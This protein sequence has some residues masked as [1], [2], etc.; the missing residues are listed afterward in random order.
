VKP[1]A[2]AAAAAAPAATAPAPA[3]TAKAE[4]VAAPAQAAAAAPAPAK[5]EPVAAA[6]APQKA[7]PVASSDG[8]DA[9]SGSSSQ[10]IDAA[11]RMLNAGDAAGA[12]L[13]MR[14]LLVAD[15]GEHHA[16]EMLARALLAQSKAQEALPLIEQIVK[17][18]SKRAAYRVLE[19]DARRMLGDY[20]GARAA[21]R[22]A[23]KLDPQTPDMRQ[24]LG[25]SD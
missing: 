11:R 14:A 10:R 1:V 24:R 23:L 21:W 20:E 18:R 5:A 13:A 16:M 12:E 9:S 6:P 2:V 22:T 3:P 25:G 8:D 15:P 19:G 7:E 17:K 4:P